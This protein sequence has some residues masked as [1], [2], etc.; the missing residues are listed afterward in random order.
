MEA[1]FA[2][3]AARPSVASSGNEPALVLS[4]GAIEFRDVSFAYET[5]HA[6]PHAQTHTPA[7]GGGSLL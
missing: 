6:L 2:L 3:R 5:R 4:G 7:A 1:M